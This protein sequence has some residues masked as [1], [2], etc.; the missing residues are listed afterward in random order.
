MQNAVR[1][2][3][4][5]FLDATAIHMIDAEELVR[6]LAAAFARVTVCFEHCNALGASTLPIRYEE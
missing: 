6:F 2:H 1:A 5:S 4:L 3:H